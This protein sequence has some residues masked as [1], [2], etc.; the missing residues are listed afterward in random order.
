MMSFHPGKLQNNHRNKKPESARTHTHIHALCLLVMRSELVVAQGLLAGLDED[1]FH[2][3]PPVVL[4][5]R[6]HAMH[7]ALAADGVAVLFA[8]HGQ[9]DVGA[10]MFEA[11]SLVTLPVD[12]I[13]LHHPHIQVIALT[14]LSK[15]TDL[16]QHRCERKRKDIFLNLSAVFKSGHM[17]QTAAADCIS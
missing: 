5:G 11:H 10:H 15:C 13:T 1:A 6:A 17:N 16:L 14:V 2:G 8:R 3:T 4:V 9:E 12:A 7:L